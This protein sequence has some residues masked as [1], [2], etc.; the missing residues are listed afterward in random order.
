MFNASSASS[1][2]SEL[3]SRY[4]HSRSAT[5]AEMATQ[6][7][8]KPRLASR[9]TGTAHAFSP[10][11]HAIR[12]NT[13]TKTKA[14]DVRRTEPGYMGLLSLVNESSSCYRPMSRTEDASEQ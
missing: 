12:K 7:K 8:R 9:A 6:A 2:Q 5:P 11:L 3:F 14:G 1:N 4:C 10:L 13:G